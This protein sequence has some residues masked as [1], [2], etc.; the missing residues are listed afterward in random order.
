MKSILIIA[1][2]I[3]VIG[4][5]VFFQD[6][7]LQFFSRV[8]ELQERAAELVVEEIKQEI[9]A[10]P[11]LYA[12]REAPQAFLT[13]AGVVQE[14]NAERIKQGLKP[15]VENAKLNAAAP[16]KVRD[17]FEKQYFAHVSP[18][19][20]DAGDLADKVTY[21]YIAIGENLALGNF[22]NDVE[23]VAGWMGSP[24]HRAN[25]MNTRYEEIGVAVA[26]GVFEGRTTWLAVQIFGR[27]R[28]ACPQPDPN[29]EAQIDS[30]KI[31]I[32]DLGRAALSLRQGIETMQP[33]RKHEYAEYNRKVSE[34]NALVR[35]L[36]S[37]IDAAKLFIAEY[38]DQV[39]IFNECAAK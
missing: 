34:Y 22:K 32:D 13:S 4:I 27:P 21:E 39:L 36:N 9:A 17:M 33:G 19:G 8:P 35:Q 20:I 2:A 24:G 26:K 7:V 23:L 12:L 18:S 37:L 14:T 10:P 1:A 6:E 30:Y 38:N 28:S 16:F 3:V 29:L 25:V 15:L 31:Q 5:A 11:P